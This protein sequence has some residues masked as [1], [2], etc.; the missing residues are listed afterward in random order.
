MQVKNATTDFQNSLQQQVQLL[1]SLAGCEHRMQQAVMRKNWHELDESLHQLQ[2]IS[3]EIHRCEQDREQSFAS[4]CRQ[5]NLP[6]SSRFAQVVGHLPD[7]NRR[8]ITSLYRRLKIAV[9]RVQTIT[10]GVDAYIN[11]TVETMNQ[12]VEEVFPGARGSV[13]SRDGSVYGKQPPAMV[14][15]HQL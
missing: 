4:L 7:E 9:L 12:I 6:E 3:E 5:L 11:T 14:V 10:S 13:Y 8:E 15:N 1:E 2:T